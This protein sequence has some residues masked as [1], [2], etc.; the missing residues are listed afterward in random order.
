M[1]WSPKKLGPSQ[2]KIKT[3]GISW[4]VKWNTT[5]T[6]WTPLILSTEK[7]VVHVI[8]GTETSQTFIKC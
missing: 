1:I 6:K 2:Y 4:Y 3:D 5:Q 8:Y 7:Q